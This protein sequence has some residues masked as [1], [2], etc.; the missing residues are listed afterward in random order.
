MITAFII[1]FVKTLTKDWENITTV[2]PKIERMIINEI[3]HFNTMH[4]IKQTATIFIKNLRL[5]KYLKIIQNQESSDC[6]KIIVDNQRHELKLSSYASSMCRDLI[7][8]LKSENFYRI[9]Q[10]YD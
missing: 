2:N 7:E 9:I 4:A 10:L 1:F 5:L 3:S 8:K 6:L